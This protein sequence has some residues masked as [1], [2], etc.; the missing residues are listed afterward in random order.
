MALEALTEYMLRKPQVPL[1]SMKVKFSN[2]EKKLQEELNLKSKEGNVE[3]EL[4]VQRYYQYF[5]L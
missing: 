2:S 1:V 4:Q 3:A 5:T